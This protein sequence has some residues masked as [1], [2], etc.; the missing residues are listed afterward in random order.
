MPLFSMPPPLSPDTFPRTTLSVIVNGPKLSML[1]P[2]PSSVAE[3]CS[4]RDPT[5]SIGPP[6]V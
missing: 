6:S 5:M 3:F 1:I 2:P 4:N